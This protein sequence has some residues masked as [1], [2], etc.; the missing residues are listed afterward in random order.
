[1]SDSPSERTK[2]FISI[3][4]IG[5]V[6][7]GKTMLTSAIT[8]VL[9]Q[10]G[11]AKERS[12]ADIAKGGVVRDSKKILTVPASHTEYE[13]ENRHYSHIDCPGHIDYIKNMITGA[14][15]MDGAILVVDSSEG[16]MPQ[17]REHIILARQVGVPSMVV[18]INKVDL[19]DDEE[20]LDLVEL[21]LMELLTQY[22]FPGEE[23]PM[24][25]G[26]ALL[27]RD[28]GCGK[29]EC[30][31]CGSIWRLLDAI[32]EHI[33][34]PPRE[35]DK[36]FL[37]PV[38]EEYSIKGRGVVVAGKIE[39]GTVKV[40][41][42]VEVVGLGAELRK[43]VVT[44]IE[45]FKKLLPQA[46]AGDDVGCLLRG[47]NLGE[48]QRG[49]VL[50]EPGT[51]TPHVQFEAQVYVLKKDEGGRHSPFFTGYRP[52]L[53]IRTMD[54]SGTVTLPETVQMAMPG[55]NVDMRITLNTPVAIET[56][57]RF[58]F[59]DGRQTVG[60]GVITQVLE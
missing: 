11:L 57:L 34:T 32:D 39:R 33:P 28:C 31:H 18:F 6:D 58:A 47:V 29:R 51:I 27:A 45:M 42:E 20:L 23:I 19:M 54:V 60:A 5:H 17:T 38:D 7:H 26:S 56:G 53:Y 50:A 41:D 10:A 8:K 1:M 4:T 25:R 48:V 22:G 49:H 36:P 43:V 12:Y 37:M 40:G 46:H 3:G 35:T 21:E 24:I 52:H 15:Q 44:S 59:R 13:T 30:P 14:A 55:D 16:P 2:P 9:A